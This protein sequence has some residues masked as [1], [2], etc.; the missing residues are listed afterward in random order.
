MVAF[1]KTNQSFC[2]ACE[3]STGLLGLPFN[4]PQALLTQQLAAQDL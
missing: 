3:T 2:F 4:P 1:F